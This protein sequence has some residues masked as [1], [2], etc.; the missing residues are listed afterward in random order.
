MP[1]MK[2][3]AARVAGVAVLG[4]AFAALGA[5]AAQAAVLPI[6]PG[7]KVAE[8]ALADGPASPS[9]ESNEA[10]VSPGRQTPSGPSAVI[11]GVPL[12]GALF[13]VVNR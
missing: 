1:K 8:G 11:A 12:G 3:S 4:A 6:A 9:N 5:G 10:V 7:V 13:G 2:K